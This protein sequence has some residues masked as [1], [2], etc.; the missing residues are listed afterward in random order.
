MKMEKQL[1]NRLSEATSIRPWW[2]VWKYMEEVLSHTRYSQER[3]E[4][5][6]GEIGDQT[7]HFGTLGSNNYKL[8][9]SDAVQFWF[10]EFVLEE[11]EGKNEGG[12]GG[13]EETLSL[14]QNPGFEKDFATDKEPV[15]GADAPSA[16]NGILNYLN[17]WFTRGKTGT[18]TVDKTFGANGS[19]QSLKYTVPELA[20]YWSTDLSYPFQGVTAGKYKL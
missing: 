16:G 18:L 2:K 4:R 15:V 9:S 14:I 19:G 17:R 5:R 1:S 13:K 11:G 12:D 20:N 10:D 8:V 7:S 6:I 3:L